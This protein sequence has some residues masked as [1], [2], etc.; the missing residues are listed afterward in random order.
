MLCWYKH[1]N[2]YDVLLCKYM[3]KKKKERKKKHLR[4][5]LKLQ[6]FYLRILKTNCFKSLVEQYVY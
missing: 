4:A 5:I 3:T 2:V 1:K 6:S